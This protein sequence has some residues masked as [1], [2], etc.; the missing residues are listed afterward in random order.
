MEDAWEFV[1]V[2]GI[3]ISAIIDAFNINYKTLLFS[4][5]FTILII[6]FSGIFLKEL[7]Y[8]IMINGRAK[9]NKDR[10]DV[11]EKVKGRASKLSK[12]FVL[13]AFFPLL[14]AFTNYLNVSANY[15]RGKVVSFIEED[16][17]ATTI[18]CLLYTSPSPRDKRQSRMPS[19]A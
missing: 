1:V 12:I 8:F 9:I 14:T 13:L 16:L 11:R 17:S 5:I 6:L 2:S 15:Y 3:D 18:T 4:I 7:V 19:S 10:H